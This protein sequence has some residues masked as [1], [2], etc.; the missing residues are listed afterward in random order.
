[1]KKAYRTMRAVASDG[2]RNNGGARDRGRRKR[3]LVGG[4]ETLLYYA[5]DKP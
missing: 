4:G 3:V 2:E 5:S 1:M